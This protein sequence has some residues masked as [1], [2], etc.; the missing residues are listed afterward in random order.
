MSMAGALIE[1]V[2]NKLGTILTEHMSLVGDARQELENHSSEFK[3]IQAVLHDAECRQISDESVRQWLV[4]LKHETYDMDDVLDEWV[5]S[6]LTSG[7]RDGDDG[8]SGRNTGW[9]ERAE[10]DTL[11]KK[12]R[13]F[14]SKFVSWEDVAQRVKGIRSQLDQITKEK[15]DYGFKENYYLPQGNRSTNTIDDFETSSLLDESKI[16]GQ[17]VDIGIIISRLVTGTDQED[18][19]VHVISIIGVGGMGKTTLA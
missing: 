8:D 17:D 6:A 7:I 18:G 2:L 13:I 11:R 19:G 16:I 15:N 10:G 1:L 4:K 12:A 3:A 5:T 14:Y 9:N